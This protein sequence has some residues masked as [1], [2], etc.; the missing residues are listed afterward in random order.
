MR[1]M[2]FKK[3]NS[4][5][6]HENS[7]L[8]QLLSYAFVCVLF[9]S[10]ASQANW[11]RSESDLN[12]QQIQQSSNNHTAGSNSDSLPAGVTQEWL[13]KLQ[14]KEVTGSFRKKNLK[15]T[16][17]GKNTF[18]GSA[19]GVNYAKSV[20]SAGDVNGDGFDDVNIGDPNGNNGGGTNSGRAYIY[21]GGINY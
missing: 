18:D 6:K 20:S 16:H 17:C 3:L 14:M 13:N 7:S 2:T 15:R 11:Q 9:I 12:T 1:Q 4:H 5:I 10:S 21:F 8:H 19:I